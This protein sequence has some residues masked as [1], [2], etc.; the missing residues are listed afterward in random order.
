MADLATLQ[1]YLANAEAARD[2]IATSGR[3]ELVERNGR[4]MSLTKANLPWLDGYILQL[5]RD[6]ETAENCAAGRPRRRHAIGTIW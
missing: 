4:R 1:T 6:I 2:T 5:Q 3:V